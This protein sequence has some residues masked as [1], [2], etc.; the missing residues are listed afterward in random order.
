MAQTR[1]YYVSFNP[2]ERQKWGGYS[3]TFDLSATG[4]RHTV[5]AD[6][7][8]KLTTEVHR[9]ARAYGRTCSAHIRVPT[10]QRKPPGFDK[11]CRTLNI[12]DFV[13]ETATA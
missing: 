5:T 10:G 6:S 8:D 4:E 11:L 3:I 13:P 7:F 12:I 2:A 1:T 9:L